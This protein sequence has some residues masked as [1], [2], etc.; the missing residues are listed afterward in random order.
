M[1][2]TLLTIRN[3][4]RHYLDEAAEKDWKN[5]DLTREINKQYHRVISAVVEVFEDY[6][7]TEATAD[8][9][10][11]QQ[12]YTL[13][14]DFSKI[15]RVEINYDIDNANSTFSRAFPINIDEVRHDLG[16]ATT[17]VTVVRNPI[18]YL[19]G[20]IIGFIPVPTEVGD[21]AI[22]IWY[23]K[24]QVD[25]SDDT[26]TINIP[27]PDRY[28]AIISKAAAS[29][30]LRKGQQEPVEAERLENEAQKDIQRMQRELE[31]RVAE[32]GKRVIDTSLNN[33]DFGSP[34]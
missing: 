17:G 18:Y 1:A 32:E 30:A 33:L 34:W 31:D 7:I 16:H 29:G 11:D 26:D 2:K 13:P 8:T 6:Y 19:Q 20:N 22:K 12:E 5:S 27:Y 23:V 21:E 28:Y 15:R 3:D 4:V 25:L 14:T 10:E 9:V 24:N